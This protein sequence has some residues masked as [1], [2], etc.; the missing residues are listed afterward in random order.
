MKIVVLTLNPPTLQLEFDPVEVEHELFQTAKTEATKEKSVEVMSE[1]I[2]Q[3][4][5]TKLDTAVAEVGKAEPDIEKLDIDKIE[6]PLPSTLIIT[7][8]LDEKE[9][10]MTV[11]GKFVDQTREKLCGDV[12]VEVDEKTGEDIKDYKT[13]PQFKIG[14]MET[15][16]TY[17]TV[18]QDIEQV[19]EDIKVEQV[20]PIDEK[21]VEPVKEETKEEIRVIK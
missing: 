13:I 8:E 7:T 1:T 21:P 15:I 12:L 11:L 16:E 20:E 5:T 6:E 18:K 14:V 9:D 10:P 2:K 4:D 3:Y 19:K 17:E